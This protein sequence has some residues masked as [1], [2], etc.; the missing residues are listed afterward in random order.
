MRKVISSQ[1]SLRSSVNVHKVGIT[2]WFLCKNP[3]KTL[4]WVRFKLSCISCN[5]AYNDLW[6]ALLFFTNSREWQ[7]FNV[8]TKMLKVMKKLAF[9]YQNLQIKRLGKDQFI[10]SYSLHRWSE[11]AA[12]VSGRRWYVWV[13]LFPVILTWNYEWF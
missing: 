2:W 10:L 9:W 4:Y 11:Y 3:I 5:L 7:G 8:N 1:V 13:V 6:I 12:R